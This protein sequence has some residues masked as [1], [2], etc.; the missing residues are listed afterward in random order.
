MAA[1][2][3]SGYSMAPLQAR[4]ALFIHPQT[5]G[6]FFVLPPYL[7][8]THPPTTPVYPGMVIGESA[9]SQDLYLNPCIKKQLTNIRAAGA[10]EKI[11]LASPRVMTLEEAL[12]YMGDD[13]IV[14]VTPGS[15]RLRKVVLDQAKR[16]RMKGGK[17]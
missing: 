10:D 6:S 2:E 12:A 4:G 5:Q 11:V 14:E 8:L 3:S 9:K 1:G 13:E 7:S 17:K 16:M 15:I